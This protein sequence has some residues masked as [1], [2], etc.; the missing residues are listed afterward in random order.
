LRRSAIFPK[1]GSITLNTTTY[2]YD[3]ASRLG[4]VSDGT[5]SGN[6]SYL[7]NS[8]LIGSITYKNG[9]TVEMTATRQY[10]YLNRL[11]SIVSS[12]AGTNQ[13]PLGYAY[14]YNDANQRTRMVLG[15]SGYWIYSY[16]TL[17]QV[18]GGVKYFSDGTPVPGQQFGYAFDDIGN[19]TLTT[20]TTGGDSSGGNIRCAS[21]INNSLNRVTSR[22]VPNVVDVIGIADPS[23]TVTVNGANVDFRR[24]ELLR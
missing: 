9:S 1:N 13:P 14:D 11:Q 2:T 8:S 10:D 16:D 19:R 20:T 4:S 5:Y 12:P 6:Y 18:T 17:G 22:G 23:T 21:Y 24:G 7:A 3:N 15:D